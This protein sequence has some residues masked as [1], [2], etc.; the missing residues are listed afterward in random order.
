MNIIVFGATGKTGQELV[1]QGLE[2]GHRVTA[3]VRNPSAI[4]LTHPNLRVVQGNITDAQS[5]REAVV[6]QD[7]AL[8][9][10]GSSDLKRHP[11]VT[12]GIRQ[13]VS[14]LEASGPRRFIYCSSLGVG[15]SLQAMRP[16][17]RYA[18]VPLLLKNPL[19]DHEEREKIIRA[20]SLEWTIVR[21]GNLTLGPRTGVYKHGKFEPGT[22]SSRISRADVAQFMLTQLTDDTYFRQSPGVS[23]SA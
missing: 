18:I 20:S 6:G 13:L 5:L 16:V 22:F 17:F 4:T 2:L 23:Y 12:E 14:I 10:L 3:F 1:T 9:G 7:A 15:D 19:L 21:P 11:E 8:S